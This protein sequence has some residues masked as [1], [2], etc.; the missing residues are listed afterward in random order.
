M[1][2]GVFAQS[3]NCGASETAVAMEQLS[4]HVSTETNTRNNKRAVYFAVRAAVL[5]TGQR[6]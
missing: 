2:F 1:Y 6:R 3:K 4:D 5:Q